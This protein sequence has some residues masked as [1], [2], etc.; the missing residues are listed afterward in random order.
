MMPPAPGLLST[1]ID[2]A[3]GAGDLIRQDA[4]QEVDAAARAEPK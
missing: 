4:D 3:F 1:M 2:L